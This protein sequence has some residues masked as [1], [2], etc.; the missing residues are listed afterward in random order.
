[1]HRF[2]KI[3][4]WQP[5]FV[6][7]FL[8]GIGL[9]NLTSTPVAC[10]DESFQSIP[11]HLIAT[12][13]EET[14]FVPPA[15]I[16]S[17]DQAAYPPLWYPDQIL[18]ES[19]DWQDYGILAQDPSPTDALFQSIH[20]TPAKNQ[21]SCG[22]CY[23]FGTVGAVESFLARMG[24]GQ[25]DLSENNAMNC[26]ARNAENPEGG[27]GGGTFLNVIDFFN[28]KGTVL[29]AD[30]PYSP[31]KAACSVSVNYQQTI[32]GWLQVGERGKIAEPSVLK[33]YLI[34]YGPLEIS[35]K[36]D[37]PGP[38]GQRFM[39][40]NGTDPIHLPLQIS[41]GVD[42]SVLLVGWN[43][44]TTHAGGRGV[45]II[46][47]SW[48]TQWGKNGLAEVAYGSANLGLGWSYVPNLHQPYN[49][50]GEL[51]LLDTYGRGKSFYL[52]AV[53]QHAMMRFTPTVS[54]CVDRVEMQLF[55]KTS[56]VDVTLYT[57]LNSAGTNPWG[58]AIQRPVNPIANLK[59]L[60][61]PSAGNFSFKFPAGIRVTQGQDIYVAVSA[62]ANMLEADPQSTAPGR[63]FVSWDGRDWM[64]DSQNTAFNI[65]LRTVACDPNA[66][67]APTFTPTAFVPTAT[68]Q[69]SPSPTPTF[70]PAPGQPTAAPTATVPAN[71]ACHVPPNMLAR[72][73][74]LDQFAG[75]SL[76]AAPLPL[77]PQ[78]LGP[79][80][81]Q[82][83]RTPDRTAGSTSRGMRLS[84]VTLQEEPPF[85]TGQV[86]EIEPENVFGFLLF[87]NGSPAGFADVRVYPLDSQGR[88]FADPIAATFSR[89]DGYFGFN[90]RN[91]DYQLDAS[92]PIL[93]GE[94][95]PIDGMQPLTQSITVS[96]ETNLGDLRLPATTKVINGSIAHTNGT[97]IDAAQIAAFNTGSGQLVYAFPLSNGTYSLRVGG[98][99]WELY[100]L[101]NPG[102]MWAPVN[103]QATVIFADDNTA[104]TRNNVNFSV[105]APDALI[106]GRITGPDGAPLAVNQLDNAG[107]SPYVSLDLFDT[108]SGAF[109]VGYINASGHFTIPVLAG[110]Y[111]ANVWLDE[112]EYPQFTGPILPQTVQVITGTVNLGNVAVLA[113]SAALQGT[114][115]DSDGRPVP[116]IFVDI[117]QENGL[118]L[119]AATDSEGR[120][121]IAAPAGEWFV[122]PSPTDYQAHLYTGQPEY[123]TLIAQ[124]TTTADFFL[125]PSAGRLFGIVVDGAN[126]LLD[127]VEAFA[128]IRRGSEGQPISFGAVE[129][130]RFV[131]KMPYGDL[132]VGVYLGPD[133]AYVLAGEVPAA[134]AVDVT[135][136]SRMSAQSLAGREQASFRQAAQGDRDVTVTLTPADAIV[137]GRLVNMAGAPIEDLFGYV[138]AKNQ[139][140]P[141]LWKWAEVDPTT[142]A[143]S[144]QL[145][146]G[147]WDL[148]FDLDVEPSLYLAAPRQ[149][150][151]VTAV[152]Q[153]TITQDLTVPQ[154]NQVVRGIVVD[155]EGNPVP[156]TPV[157]VRGVDVEAL[158]RS[159]PDGSFV[160]YIA[161]QNPANGRQ[162]GGSL[163][164]GTNTLINPT[165]PSYTSVGVSCGI[166]GCANAQ[167]TDVIAD[168]FP[169]SRSG[170]G[171][172]S[173]NVRLVVRTSNAYLTGQVLNAWDNN[174]PVPGASVTGKSNDG[175]SFSTTTDANGCFSAP[176]KVSGLYTWEITGKFQDWTDGLMATTRTT[177][178][179]SATLPT[180]REE[181]AVA[182]LPAQAALRV[183]YV[184]TA[185]APML[186][187]FT[188]AQGWNHT[189][190][191]GFT[192]EIPANAI[193]TREQQ[194]VIEIRPSIAMPN[195][196]IH[197]V[198]GYG[199]E[200]NLRDRQG[201]LI[202]APFHQDMRL[203]FR[204]VENLT[205]DEGQLS[206]ARQSG[207]TWLVQPQAVQDRT[208]NSYAVTVNT[209]GTYA[210]V[211]PSQFAIQTSVLYLPSV[212]R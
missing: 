32:L 12:Y 145:T 73:N 56:N 86:E 22:S 160:V 74:S 193:N 25:L 60:S 13:N 78:P 45:W 171:A 50:T 173:V 175:Q 208:V 97:P 182:N 179:G 37:N 17:A 100:L 28:K 192:I 174:K 142:G 185:P 206:V 149:P 4:L 170:D 130:G 91:G 38:T 141:N 77:K 200:I 79:D 203:T 168:G 211:V 212:Q 89:E 184:G 67:V 70:T 75:D 181:G 42:H 109:S 163:T 84:Q 150:T 140:N 210:L 164:A 36:A 151:T 19:F 118:W 135:D 7:L 131:L 125:E 3:R 8:A 71:E 138:I 81:F 183:A 187:T 143:Y 133:T 111:Y 112:E 116:G 62:N 85:F 144:L 83:P 167:P 176:V 136:L 27:C 2:S 10:A 110:A 87:P 44:N 76:A 153:S 6:F 57:G 88:P 209:P 101:P 137:S 198:P 72:T 165:D 155:E 132:N 30:D 104:E 90:L 20:V 201:R 54:A 124:Q 26:N 69:P 196:L 169:L 93:D 41:D 172:E 146:G 115:R 68:P 202:T 59:G 122:E 148:T 5:L 47:N 33:N 51:L 161:N 102:V 105:T 94:G 96:G 126:T 129:N 80:R 46:K 95:A 82:A 66:P 18:P 162:F 197:D 139:G 108:K 190:P 117:W 14:D 114:V 21:A 154:I 24:L 177:L 119:Y 49:S 61:S 191:D 180:T 15:L 43:D 103:R 121:E 195:S 98:G 107:F 48:G 34:N 134:R 23:A 35:V 29:E 199:Y 53:G 166:N 113:N 65:R 186:H 58:V 55:G 157:W 188:V 207:A 1:M 152:A 92:P 64:A 123:V 16:R 147:N 39:Q 9:F 194:V 120:Y 63:S 205:S 106:T 31:M 178:S 52:S 159:G 11:P 128:Y 127:G 189:L 204:Y 99:S 156:N 158:T 40:Y